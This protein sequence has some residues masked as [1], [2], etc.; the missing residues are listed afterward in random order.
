MFTW[1]PRT[2]FYLLATLFV[3]MHV[4]MFR[5]YGIRD[6]HDAVGYIISA[7]ELINEGSLVKGHNFFYSLHVIVLAGFLIFFKSV[8]PFL[9]F[10]IAVSF[11]AM[12]FLYRAVTQL[13][14]RTV[15]LISA[16]TFV[17]WWDN[18]HWNSTTMTESL[19]LSVGCFLLFRLSFF[20]GRNRDFVYI[21]IL[22]LVSMLLRPTGIVLVLGVIAFLISYYW[23]MLRSR[24]FVLGSLAVGIVVAMLSSAYVLLNIWDFSDQYVRGNIVTYVDKI[25]PAILDTSGLRVLPKNTEFVNDYQMPVQKIL[26]FVYHNPL[27]F[28]EAGV[29]KVIYLLSGYRPYYSTLHNAFSIVWMLLMY[30]GFA[31]GW[32]R[33]KSTPIIFF[34]V[35]VVGLNCLLIF[36]SSVDWDNR[37]Y[38]P[39]EPGIILLSSFGFERLF[40]RFRTGTTSQ[41]S[42]N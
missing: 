22:L 29:L 3:V 11:T 5:I 4:A 1:I 33:F 38:I 25:D 6:L 23:P 16:F 13:G 34:V 35:G 14:D 17:C 15:A 8:I 24:Y 20:V 12:L 41:V 21:S 39:M 18:L 19:F 37:F 10:Q 42:A 30:T 31:G 7:N 40:K 36:I 28:L 27:E 2:H 32:S 26:M 9:L